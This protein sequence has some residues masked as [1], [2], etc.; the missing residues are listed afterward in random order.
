MR[1]KEVTQMNALLVLDETDGIKTT[2]N[3]TETQIREARK[4]CPSELMLDFPTKKIATKIAPLLMEF[5]K[6]E[7]QITIVVHQRDSLLH[8]FFPTPT[9]RDIQVV[10][11]VCGQ[12]KGLGKMFIPYNLGMK[13]NGVQD[14]WE[15]F[16]ESKQGAIA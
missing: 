9:N 4:M 6:E 1:K 14:R 16:A 11:D 10:R 7:E 8:I 13:S 3:P 5:I 2:E 12:I 15:E